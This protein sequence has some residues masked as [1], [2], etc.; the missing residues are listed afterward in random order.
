[1]FVK[2]F[3][4]KNHARK[5]KKSKKTKMQRG[6]GATL[7]PH[8]QKLAAH[9]QADVNSLS[10]DPLK[11]LRAQE[12]AA[13]RMRQAMRDTETLKTS[14]ASPYVSSRHKKEIHDLFTPSTPPPSKPGSIRSARIPR[15]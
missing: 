14:L 1:M 5:I 13:K 6:G 10:G 3:T 15:G 4:K 2:R 7:P 12:I 8:L 11:Q 9:L